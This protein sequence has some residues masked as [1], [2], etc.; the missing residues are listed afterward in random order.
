[1]FEFSTI[2]PFS[3]IQFYYFFLVSVVCVLCAKMFFAKKIKFRYVLF[4]INAA[5]LLFLFPKP[6]QLIF[7]IVYSFISIR[8]LAKKKASY[9]TAVFVFSLPL[10]MMKLIGIH[11]FGGL[12]DK[13]AIVFQ[14]IGISYI[15]FRSIQVFIDESSTNEKLNFLDFFNFTVFIPSLLI[16]PID[17]F[18]RF[19]SDVANGYENINWNSY[20]IAYQFLLKGLVYKYIL[21]DFINRLVLNHLN[22]DG[23]FA[24]HLTYMYAYLIFLFFDFAGYSL[25]AMSFAKFIGISLPYNFNKPFLA[26]NPKE[27]WQ[28]WHKSLGDWL[29]DYFFKPIFKDLTTKQKFKPITRQNIALFATFTLMGFWNGF[30]LHY[31]ISGMLFGFYSMIHNYYVYLC[32]KNKKDVFFGNLNPKLVSFISIVFMFNAVAFSIYIFSG[33]LF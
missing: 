6:L 30:E 16:G 26:V 27:F 22:D 20:T 5:Y 2:L 9:L 8:V 15:T 28:R 23:S 1:M 3:S 32:K 17:R 10:I 12:N 4:F 31:I 18:K 33:K 11:V 25:L 21:A 29:N 14:I 19:S 13:L 7:L 24:Y